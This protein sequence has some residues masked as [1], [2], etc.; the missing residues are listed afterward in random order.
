MTALR[1][2]FLDVSE[3]EDIESAESFGTELAHWQRGVMFWMGDLQRHAER[4]WPETYHQIWP[5]WIS[6]GLLARAAA[7]A[8]AYPKESDR[9][10]PVTWTQYMQVAN[11]P[12]RKQRLESIL[13]KGQTSDES[14]Q[15][16]KG[17]DTPK[18]RWLLA[19]D[20]NYYVH[21]FYHS[22]SGVESASEVAAW[23]DRT[24]SRLMDMGLTDVLC[25]FDSP[26]NHRKDL[27]EAWEGG[28]YKDRPKKEPEL[29]QQ[30]HAVR[31]LL[32]DRH[33]LLCHDTDGMEA[34]DIMASAAAQ[35]DGRVTLLAQDK[36][37][38]QCL[39]ATCN[40]LMDVEWSEDPTSGD[41]LPHYKWYTEKPTARLETLRSQHTE[42]Q[43]KGE[44]FKLLDLER[45][46][47]LEPRN[48][49]D[50]FGL[51]VDQWTDFQCLMGDQ[52]D[53]IKG[54]PGIGQ[55][56]AASLLKQFDTVEGAI[57]AAKEG[58]ESITKK[59]RE[60]LIAFESQLPITRQLVTMKTDLLIPQ[61]T[62]LT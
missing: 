15:A 54:C 12:D 4:K 28:K 39:S 45:L 29:V 2:R 48:L 47:E 41:M 6:P 36:D 34:D 30:L 60:A 61:T 50:E 31:S 51:R 55:K 26:R 9:S 18:R 27:T 57:A 44:A 56:I 17:D 23:I 11:R 40:M 52:T 49:Q 14:R 1:E 19:I 3:I 16:L 59:K 8:R 33:G 5:E 32:S 42:A 58:H 38:R 43:F 35:F 20:V 10:I 7:V 25:C 62:R 13:E 21:R 22:G 24:V 37:L 46:M 53:G